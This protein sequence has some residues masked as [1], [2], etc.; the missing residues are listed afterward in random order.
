MLATLL[1]PILKCFREEMRIL[2]LVSPMVFLLLL[3]SMEEVE[4]YKH[5]CEVITNM[6]RNIKA[7]KSSIKKIEVTQASAMKIVKSTSRAIEG[8]KKAIEAQYQAI[9]DQ[10]AGIERRSRRRRSGRNKNKKLCDD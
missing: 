3:A 4:G 1:Y 6:Q 9:R 10:R 2:L 5:A 8:K 7:M